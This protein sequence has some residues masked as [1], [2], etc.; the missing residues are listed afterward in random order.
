[1]QS[2]L[3]FS[4]QLLRMQ[5]F[6]TV[7]VL[8]LLS[9]SVHAH[10][11]DNF[12]SCKEYFYEGFVPQGLTSGN[13]VYICQRYNN[14]YHFATLYDTAH[15]IPVYSAYVFES[16]AKTKRRR[17]WFVE[18]QLA[19]RSLAMKE[20]KTQGEMK[21]KNILKI[22]DKQAVDADYDSLAPSWLYDHGHLNPCG[23]HAEEGCAATF[24][25]TNVVPQN[26]KLN[27]GPW[28]VYE[29]SSKEIFKK[30]KTAF[31]LVGAIPSEANWLQRGG[32]NRV[33]VPQSLW[34]AFCCVDKNQQASSGA[35][36]AQ[37]M[38]TQVERVALAEL[39]EFLRKKLNKAEAPKLFANNCEA[40]K[41]P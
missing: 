33:N 10:V 29:T 22:E 41:K 35:A 38:D 28:A 6:V 2:V 15:R 25:L 1:M 4:F 30:C 37:N 16:N 12:E 31:V 24:T 11:V 9:F 14:K 8:L 17:K 20:M 40:V 36:R 39:Q 7:C 19:D 27:N 21:V 13:D 3:L 23:H 32:V 34:Q 5:N 18:P 26:K